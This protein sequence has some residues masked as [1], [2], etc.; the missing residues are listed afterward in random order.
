[1][2]LNRFFSKI[3][4]IN[5][6]Y[7]IFGSL[8]YSTGFVFFIVPHKLIIGGIVGLSMIINNFIAVPIGTITLIINIPI[9]LLGIKTLGSRFGIKTLLSL[10]SVSFFID[11]FIY[12]FGKNPVTEDIL[13]SIIFGSMLIGVGL[14]FVIKA[15]A[16][17]GGTDIIASIISKKTF[18]QIGQIILFVDGIIIL[19]GIAV[20]KRIEMLPYAVIAIFVIS[21]I[22]DAVINGLNRKNIILIISEKHEEIRNFILENLNRGGT[23]L[24]SKGLYYKSRKKNIIF[25]A[26]SKRETNKLRKKALEIDK[27][28]FI[29]VLDAYEVIGRGFTL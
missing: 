1:M 27:E 26:L 7:L 10:V 17:T 19:I 21:K 6:G 18:L 24:D 8:I 29:T 25:T 5:Y 13:A 2:K 16:T 28:A 4:I 11:F 12:L 15:N 3:N 14:A 20:F 9:F 22:T 23:Y